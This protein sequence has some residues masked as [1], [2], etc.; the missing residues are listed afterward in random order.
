MNSA[1]GQ[2]DKLYAEKTVNQL[3]KLYGALLAKRKQEIE[4][5]LSLQL[6]TIKARLDNIY[7]LLS[8]WKKY[9]DMIYMP[10]NQLKFVQLLEK[11]DIRP[12]EIA[13]KTRMKESDVANRLN[14][15]FGK[16]Q[17]VDDKQAT[18]AAYE[19]VNEGNTTDTTSGLDEESIVNR[20]ENYERLKKQK[21]MYQGREVS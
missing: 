15:L 3:R 11:M 1:R 16:G 17:A 14:M 18:D 12:E 19:T 7:E 9:T 21:E 2:A 6:K 10:E 20:H 4:G 8:L 13:Y 5:N